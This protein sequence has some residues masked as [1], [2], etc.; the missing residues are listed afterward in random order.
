[1]NIKD[2]GNRMMMRCLSL[3]APLLLS[4]VTACAA[5]EEQVATVPKQAGLAGTRW[6]LTSIQ[7][8]DDA[9]GTTTPSD[10]AHY[11]LDF[12]ADGRAAIRLDCNRGTATWTAEPAQA[13]SGNLSFGPV[14]STKM[15]CPSPS[16]GEQLARQLPY[17]RT[18]QISDGRLH[19]SLMADG[20]ILTWAP[21][22]PAR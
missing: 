13:N 11:T 12:G 9:Q 20:G 6:Q 15:L 18:Y 17:V 10:P 21:V 3:T 7:S 2:R 8:M 16:L 5:K 22:G 19:M 14:A 4:M 1:M